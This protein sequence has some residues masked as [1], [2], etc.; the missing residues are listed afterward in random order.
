MVGVSRGLSG[1][2]DLIGLA[3][4]HGSRLSLFSI[5]L[6]DIQCD[7]DLHT[8]TPTSPYS[9]NK[10]SAP[11]ILSSIPDVGPLEYL[12]TSV[13]ETASIPSHPFQ[14]AVHIAEF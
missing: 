10:I 13:S 2:A 12:S 1:Y 7:S 14:V 4:D 3:N 11:M 5:S 8:L 9:M 6:S